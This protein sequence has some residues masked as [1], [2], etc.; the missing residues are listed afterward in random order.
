MREDA[1]FFLGLQAPTVIWSK[2]AQ[3]TTT[4]LA[5][6]LIFPNSVNDCF[7]LD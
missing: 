5:A 1:F 4:R 6:R 7:M 2:S 3:A